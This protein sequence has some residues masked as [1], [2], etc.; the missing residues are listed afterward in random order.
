VKRR[1][2][3]A[4]AVAPALLSLTRPAAAARRARIGVALPLTG[5]QAAV[6][7]E[8][9]AGYQLAFALGKKRGIDAELVVEDDGSMPQ[10]T[11]AIIRRFGVDGTFSAITGIVGTPHAKAAI[12]EARSAALPV[13]GIRSGAGELRD[14]GPW[15]YHLRASYEAEIRRMAG[16]LKVAS[17][18]VAVVY[19]KDSFGESAVAYLRQIA[20]GVGLEIVS[21]QAADRNGADVASAVQKACAQENRAHSLLVLMI[22]RPTVEALKAA[23][24]AGFLGATFAMSFTAGADLM[25][26]GVDLV[27]GLGLISAFPLPRASTDATSTAYRQGLIEIGREGLLNSLTA[28]EGFSYGTAIISAIERCGDRVNRES[29]TQCLVAPPGVMIAGEALKFDQ[30]RVGRRYLEVMYFDSMGTLR[31]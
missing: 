13:I 22:T 23:R 21:A 26:A 17:P 8:L 24:K 31:K 5:V 2:F 3:M 7:D 4:S 25:S 20:P 16:M 15:L 9:L 28:F 10:K 11:A 27:R 18:R 6:A 12:P 30:Q 1:A 19:S 29:L 14:G